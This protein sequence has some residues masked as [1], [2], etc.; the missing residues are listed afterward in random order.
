MGLFKDC[1]CGCN[2]KKQQ[3]KLTISIIS[4]LLFFIV[5]NPSTFLLVKKVLGSRISSPTGCPT[6]LGLI[7]HAVVF[8][9]IV[10][11]MMNVRKSSG[12]C[13]KKNGKKGGK[14]VVAE[15]PQMVDTPS[16]EPEFS[17]PKVEVTTSGYKLQPMAISSEGALYD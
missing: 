13:S 7:V 8:T 5:A 14:K 3:E 4:G 12:G 17:E 11:G 2:G 10:W 1:G 6:T 16:A 9:L 15:P